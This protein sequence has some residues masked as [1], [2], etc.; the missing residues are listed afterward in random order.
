MIVLLIATEVR[1][2]RISFLVHSSLN[3]L[4]RQ[5]PATGKSMVFALILHQRSSVKENYNVNT[6]ELNDCLITTVEMYEMSSVFDV[7]R[8]CDY[9]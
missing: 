1:E 9:V 8:F 7:L 6:R 4:S 3:L 5:T 2:R